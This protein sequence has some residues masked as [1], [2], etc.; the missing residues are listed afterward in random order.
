[1]SPKIGIKL[2]H[3]KP[4]TYLDLPALLRGWNESNRNLDAL[5]AP[6]PDSRAMLGISGR[7][8]GRLVR[9]RHNA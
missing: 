5:D 3:V 8:A 9:I 2:L 7:I 6:G 1:M 4:D